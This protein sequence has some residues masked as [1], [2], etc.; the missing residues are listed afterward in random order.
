MGFNHPA[1]DDSRMSLFEEADRGRTVSVR[2]SEMS[3][4][5]ASKEPE[6][7]RLEPLSIGGKLKKTGFSGYSRSSV[8]A[9]VSELRRSSNQLRDNMKQQLQSLSTECARLKSESQVLRGQLAQAEE[10][11][12]QFRNRLAAV[13]TERDAAE[14][15]NS[16]TDAE[17]K[18]MEERIA[19][20]EAEYAKVEELKSAL[21]EK[22][23]ENSALLEEN[24][25]LGERLRE[26]ARN[27]KQI[28]GEVAEFKKQSV[29]EHEELHR[30]KQKVL[31][32]RE[33]NDDLRSE[34][35]SLRKKREKNS[36]RDGG[37]KSSYSG[38]Y[39]E[40]LKRNMELRPEKK[41]EYPPESRPSEQDS[42]SSVED[43]QS[44]VRE[45]LDEIQRQQD[46]YDRLSSERAGSLNEEETEWWKD[47]SQ[48]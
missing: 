8:D 4:I 47:R 40:S 35:K 16:E 32:L 18:G 21:Q 17:L 27:L 45:L 38:E 24:R 10:Q 48:L 12:G 37:K 15:R 1:V 29:E 33:E 11:T 31:S 20:C 36:K 2:G 34:L 22:T 39:E 9:Y 46:M 44:A 26:Y 30:L 42:R 3:V 5:T 7:V 43:L 14:H 6:D 25:R 13:T 19:F 28:D 41:R 23:D